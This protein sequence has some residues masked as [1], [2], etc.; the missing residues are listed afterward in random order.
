ML[1]L[2]LSRNVDVLTEATTDPAYGGEAG[3]APAIREILVDGTPV[4][5]TSPAVATPGR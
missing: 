5:I 1:T 3:A 4:A 2:G